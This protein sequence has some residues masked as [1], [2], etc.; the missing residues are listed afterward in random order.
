MDCGV[1]TVECDYYMVQDWLWKQAAGNRHKEMLCIQCLS[2]RLGRRLTEE[3]FTDC[4]LNYSMGF[5]SPAKKASFSR[6]M[7]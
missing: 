2:I 4:S 3:D 1:D 5:K 6:V 7:V